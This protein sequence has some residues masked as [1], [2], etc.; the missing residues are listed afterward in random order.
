M[1]ALLIIAFQTDTPLKW[2]I[3]GFNY[4]NKFKEVSVNNDDDKLNIE[5]KRAQLL[6][7]SSR[8]PY[9]VDLNIQDINK[10]KIIELAES[11]INPAQ[12]T[13]WLNKKSNW[14]KSID[15]LR[16]NSNSQSPRSVFFSPDMWTMAIIWLRNTLLIQLM[17]GLAIAC[18]LILPRHLFI[19][20]QELSTLELY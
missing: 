1:Y 15:L 17:L 19:L 20:Y 9:H 2:T 13:S 16:C 10:Y 3:A 14:K 4:E 18:L 11:Y 12:P 7:N 8:A 6:N 5:L